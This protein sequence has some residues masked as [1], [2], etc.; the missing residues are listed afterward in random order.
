MR[1][2][3]RLVV[4]L[5]LATASRAGAATVNYVYDAAGRVVAAG[6]TTSTVP[7]R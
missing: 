5:V 7:S 3:A 6:E 4:A 2:L 1:L